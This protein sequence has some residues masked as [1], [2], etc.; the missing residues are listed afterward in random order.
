MSRLFLR[1]LSEANLLPDDE[2]YDLTVEWLIKEDDGSVRGSG[3]T[4]YRGLSD[5]ADP[6]LDWLANPDNTVVYLPSQF[7]L[8]VSCQVPGRNTTQIRR[9]LAFAAE[10]FVASDIELMQI[11]HGEIKPGTAVLCNIIS[12]SVMENWLACFKSLQVN[13]GLFVSE[14]AVLPNGPGVASVLFE[15]DTALVASSNQAAVVDRSNLTFALNTLELSE[16]YA[17]NGELS[18]I[19]RGQLDTNP[20]VENVDL[21]PA[22]VLDYLADQLSSA[23]YINLLQ[24]RYRP[25]RPKSKSTGRWQNVGGLAALWL[26][27][28]LVGLIAQGWWSNSQADRL[29]AQ[30]FAFY[31]S[32]FPNESQPSS[33]EQLR[34]RMRAKLGQNSNDDSGSAFVG[35]TAQFANIIDRNSQVDSLSYTDQK[36]ELTIEVMLE[37]YAELDVIKDKLA[38]NG[39]AV[40]VVSAE[41][42]DAGARSRLRVRYSQ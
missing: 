39:V 1:V 29:E 30:S 14:S 7:V 41:Q 28:A 21:S 4:D 9:A 20:T 16:I 35:L 36:R 12:H 8:M 10:E 37:S 26:L 40:E 27:I 3:T 31:E 5:I 11:A 42:V 25:V 24:E 32:A 38:R 18:E 6:N 22:G 19:E 15:N 34:R 33:L 17:I 2:G 13:P 23:N